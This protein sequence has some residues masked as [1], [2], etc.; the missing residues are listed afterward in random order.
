MKYKDYNSFMLNES[1]IMSPNV[2]ANLELDD[3]FECEYD[4]FKLY[5]NHSFVIVLNSGNVYLYQKNKKRIKYENIDELNKNQKENVQKYSIID[6]KN[7]QFIKKQYE[8]L[9]NCKVIDIIQLINNKNESWVGEEKH[10]KT[11]WSH[12]TKPNFLGD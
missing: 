1:K 4:I 10:I 8:K 11:K 12:I 6:T 2:F 7:G 9:S 3:N 5:P